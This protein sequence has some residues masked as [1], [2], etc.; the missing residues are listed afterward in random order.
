MTSSVDKQIP[1]PKNR[2][3]GFH[4]RQQLLIKNE[5]LTQ[6][7]PANRADTQ[8]RLARSRTPLLDLKYEE[9][10]P[11]ELR[12]NKLLFLSLN[13]AI[14]GRSIRASDSVRKDSHMV[15]RNG[16]QAKTNS[17]LRDAIRPFPGGLEKDWIPGHLQCLANYDLVVS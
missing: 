12:A 17:S 2:K 6:W 4:Q 11:F 8:D 7:K 9:P 16:Q 15:H 3:P 13:L 10:L 14:E 5:E 1:N